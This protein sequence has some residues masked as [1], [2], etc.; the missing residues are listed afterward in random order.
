[1][2]LVSVSC[3][4]SLCLVVRVC[5]LVGCCFRV[6]FFALHLWSVVGWLLLFLD[7]VVCRRVFVVCC[8]C[9]LCVNVVRCVCS[10]FVVV[11]CCLPFVSVRCLLW[12]LLCV[13]VLLLHVVC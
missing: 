1:M 10:L 4:L 8:C 3:V 9:M 13:W 2:L 11:V 7:V 6:F 5:W 12:V